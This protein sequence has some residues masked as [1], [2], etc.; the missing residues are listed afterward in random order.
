[1]NLIEIGSGELVSP[2]VARALIMRYQ[3]AMA[4]VEG[5]FGQ[6]GRPVVHKFA[7][8][9][10]CREVHLLAGDQVVGRIHRH[11]HMNF[12]NRGSVTVFTE[13]GTDEHKAG[14]SF[15]S[16]AGTKRVVLAHQDTVW[17]T[18]HPNP[19]N[20]TDVQQ[21]VDR[22]TAETYEEIGMAVADLEQLT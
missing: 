22:Y 7:P 12:I 18:V 16:Q 1:M 5:A 19:D 20:C 21:L 6:D 9:V 11:E 10:Y 8:G 14:D 17:T 3:N 13:F 2:E 4:Q 15:V